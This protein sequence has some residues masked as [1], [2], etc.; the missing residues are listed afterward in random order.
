MGLHDIACELAKL[1]YW[2]VSI[3]EPLCN[4]SRLVCNL[5]SCN[6]FTISFVLPTH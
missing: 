2:L 5:Q 3:I 1:C 4:T 6:V